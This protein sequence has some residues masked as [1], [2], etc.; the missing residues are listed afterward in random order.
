[1]GKPAVADSCFAAYCPILIDSYTVFQ[2]NVT[3]IRM[4]LNYLHAKR[5]TITSDRALQ[6]ADSFQFTVL[7]LTK[8]HDQ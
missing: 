8:Y 5:L 3:L 6:P 4:L 2:I 7:P 1:M